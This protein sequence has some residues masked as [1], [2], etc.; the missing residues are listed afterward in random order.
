MTQTPTLTMKTLLR[1]MKVPLLTTFRVAS[2]TC[3]RQRCFQTSGTTLA[4]ATETLRPPSLPAK[5]EPTLTI[6]KSAS[7][8]LSLLP[9]PTLFRSYLIT[10][11]SS[12]PVLLTPSLRFL[13][14]LAH[15]R[16][17]FLQPER[18]PFLKYILKKTFYAQFCAGETPPEVRRTVA[19]LKKTGFQGV[20]LAYAREIVLEPG[21]KIEKKADDELEEI[22]WWSRGT[23]ETIKLS[24]KGEYAG[25]K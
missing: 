12:N 1:P 6:T 24:E 20:I 16:S 23:L 8:P 21:V 4:T 22:E 7:P 11:L 25:F 5:Q 3:E 13:S 17:A 9:L 19:Q 15:S 18:N 10:A 14:L 2:V